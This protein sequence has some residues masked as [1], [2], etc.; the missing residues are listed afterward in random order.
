MKQLVLLLFTIIISFNVDA[1]RRRDMNRIPQTN[2]QP[3]DQE[4]EKRKRMIEDRKN[5]FIAN[6]LIT[7]EGDEFQKEIVKQHLNSFYDEK[8]AVLKTPF[9]RSFERE[10][11]IKK[12]ENTHF[13]DLKNLISEDDMLKIKEMITGKF[14]EKEVKKEK[15]KKKKRKRNKD[16]G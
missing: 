14:D 16:K 1:Q 12:L 15:K 9:E 7:L 2:S 8:M 3:S 4:I 5:E 13:A 11:A 6:F 10:Q